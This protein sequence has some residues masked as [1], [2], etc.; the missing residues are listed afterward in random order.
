MKKL[1]LAA[2][3]VLS[4]QA[5]AQ[6][7]MVESAAIYLRNAEMEDA[8]K[9][10]DLAIENPETKTDAKAWFYYVAIL[11]TIYRNPA[12]EKLV[13]ADLPEKFFNGCKKCIEFDVK[14]RYEYYC[15]DNAILN[16]AFMCFNKGISAYEKKDYKAAI[17]YYQMVLDVLPYDKNEVLKTNNLSEK[18]IYLYMAYS[19]IQ[20]GDN[21]KAKIYLQKLMDLNYDDHL[22]Y[23]QMANIYLE[24]KDTTNALKFIDLGRSKFSTNKDLINQELN[25]YLA[26]GRQDVLLT[27]LDGALETNPDDHQL[28]YVRGSVYDNIANDQT[29]KAKN[30]K[31]TIST[32]KKK[33]VAEKV[34]AKKASL[35]AAAANC[36]MQY[37]EQTAK[38]KEA[39]SKAESDYKKVVEL[40]P[41]YIDAYYNLGALNN[42]KTTEIVEKINAIPSN[43]TQAEYDKRYNPLKKQKDDILNV[44][45]GYFKQA[46]EIAEAKTEDTPEKKNEKY[47]Y[48]RDILYS[49]QQVYA[50]LDNEKMAIET[51]KKRDLYE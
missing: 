3:A 18:N 47:A 31:D 48:M 4:L 7:S 20:L 45:L 33:A 12:Y 26:M 6:K 9:S 21:P 42:N 37:D 10:I 49:M 43:A 40:N 30:S 22:I 23:M 27:K 32:L 13:E 8:K 24:D 39:A 29:K 14:K 35:T 50:N 25:V 15:K 44:S 16:S 38:S 28:Y 46:I 5:F 17:N 51:K 34:P 41:D 2:L 11:D 19:A 1:L 36:Q